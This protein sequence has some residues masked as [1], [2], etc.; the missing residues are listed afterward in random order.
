[1]EKDQEHN[2]RD[3]HCPCKDCEET[4]EEVRESLSNYTK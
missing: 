3:L 4:R 1:M 2:P